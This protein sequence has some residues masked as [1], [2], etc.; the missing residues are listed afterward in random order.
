MIPR[1]H[2]W[3]VIKQ[4]ELMKVMPELLEYKVSRLRLLSELNIAD[5]KGGS[6]NLKRWGDM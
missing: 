6:R 2:L 1:E 3:S 4:Y 5:S